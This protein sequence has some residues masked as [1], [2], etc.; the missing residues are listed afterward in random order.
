MNRRKFLNQVAFASL[1]GLLI[2]TGLLSSC[3][4]EALL[5]DVQ[6]DG[7][8]LI[9]GAGAAGLYAGYI[10]KSKG[11]DFE[12]LEASAVHGGRMGKLSG[13]ADCDIDTGAQWLHGR[14][15]ILG[16]LAKKTSTVTTLDDTEMSYWYKDAVV[17]SLPQDPFIFEQ[18]DLPDIS[19]KDYAHSQGLGTDYDSIIEAI[20]G[21]QGAS[22]SALS[23]Y[24]NNKEEENWVSGD[25]DFKFKKTYFDLI[26]TYIAQP[27]LSKIV[28][29]TIVQG[30]NYQ[31]DKISVTDATG[32]VWTADK[33]ILT[34]PISILKSNEIIFQPA[35]PSTK[36]DAFGKIGMGPGMKVFLKF[37]SAFYVDNL[38][39]GPI[40]AA[41][42]ADYVGKDT[43]D[44]VLLAFVMGDQAAY[45]N[46][47]GS[48]LAITNALLAELDQI[49]DGQASAT[50]IASS[51]HDYTARP[52]IKGAYSYSTI[53]MGN[54][55]EIA[56]QE[57][58]KK[59]FFAGEAMNLNGNHQTAHGAVE[60]GY[61]AVLDV[62]NSVK[63]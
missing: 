27:I 32:K 20:A 17:S 54:A 46:S 35:L 18:D 34:V 33:V 51:V 52:F 3:R 10:L 40:C 48:D 62:L 25:E 22:A 31:S 14:N 23:A 42:A 59:L 53:G 56:A 58:D 26:D 4:K 8:V 29:N 39:G 55:R 61:K 16:D 7:K 13:F 47:L 19:F 63:K 43:S 28:Y 12:I 41:Y 9:I 5:E 50:F 6:Y 2:P 15:N 24:W 57:V 60:S 45:L 11:V 1:G 38:L 21:D 37:S 30:I 49:Y 44:H 36:T